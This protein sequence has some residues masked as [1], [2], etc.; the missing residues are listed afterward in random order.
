MT[1]QCDSYHVTR[2]S[3]CLTP[4]KVLTHGDGST[5][6]KPLN[7]SER[8]Y[9]EFVAALKSERE[10]T[11]RLAARIDTLVIERDAAQASQLGHFDKLVN[12]V[13]ARKAAIAERDRLRT[14][15]EIS[16]TY[17]RQMAKQRDSARKWAARWKRCAKRALY[18]DT[19]VVSTQPT[20]GRRITSVVVSS[21]VRSPLIIEEEEC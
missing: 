7:W 6:T 18:G 3:V 11:V 19:D 10:T 5:S 9:D 13:E 1:E 16:L 21:R 15:A 2:C 17:Y 20:P 8:K 4:V 12:A 14:D